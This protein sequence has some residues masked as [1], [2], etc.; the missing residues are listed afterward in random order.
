MASLP[1]KIAIST[2]CLG[3][4]PSH[5]LTHKIHAAAQQGFQGLEIVYADLA[6]YST[7]QNIPLTTGA[8]QIRQLCDDL[9]LTV[10]SLAPFENFE[11][12]ESSIKERLAVATHWLD[13]A[14]LLGATYLQVPS[15]YDTNTN[16][17][18]TNNTTTNEATI[19][20]ELQQLADLASSSSPVISIA[21]EPLSWGIAYSTWLDA[22]RLT[23]LVN[24]PNFGLCL[25][26]F[27]ELTKL[28][29][30]PFSASGVYPDGAEKLANSLR[31][32]VA[33]MPV[34]K[35]FYV[36]LSDAERFKPPF[37]EN[38]P[39]YVEGEAPEFT[40]SR[41]AR[42]FPF[43]SGLGAYLPIADVVRAWVVEAG[44][45]GWV[46]MEIFDRRMRDEN[47]RPERAAERGWRSWEMVK[48]AVG[49]GG[50]GGLKV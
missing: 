29:A 47:Y 41:H 31:S 50:G 15:Q 17:T 44:F 39:W 1:N 48:A 18:T 2:S 40:W 34:E 37:S 24:R 26:T 33:A 14:R 19:I 21:Y 10:L 49:P 6:N 22:L 45:G 20:S 12:T 16:N 43:E 11:G 3:Q 28:W 32:F 8:A 35:V 46:S 7:T 38:H 4:N 25:D 5:S 23:Q 30:S 42:P 13:L 27:H 36:Q 9:G